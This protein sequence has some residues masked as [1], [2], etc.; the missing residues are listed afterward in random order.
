MVSQVNKSTYR[1]TQ[2]N[3]LSFSKIPGPIFK[4]GLGPYKAIVI[5]DYEML[6]DL[7]KL[8]VTTDRPQMMQWANA[9]FRFGNGNDSRGLLFR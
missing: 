2:L 6:K 1:L 5:G 8:D 9:Y 3:Q 4:V 7:F